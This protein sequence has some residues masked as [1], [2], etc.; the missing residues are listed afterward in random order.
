[1]GSL[2][3]MT[4]FQ[5]E[6]YEDVLAQVVD[7]CESGKELY[8]TLRTRLSCKVKTREGEVKPIYSCL[9]ECVIDKGEYRRNPLTLPR[10]APPP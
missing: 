3:F 1:M 7:A 4:N 8:T 9:N 6:R 5:A 2:G 10:L